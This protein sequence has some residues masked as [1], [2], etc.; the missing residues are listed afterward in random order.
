MEA[1]SQSWQTT[2]PSTRNTLA[3]AVAIGLG[4]PRMRAIRGLLLAAGLFV[5]YVLAARWMFVHW[6][7]WLNLVYPL[8]ALS[9]NYLALTVYYYVSEERQRKQIKETFRQYVSPV[10]V[11]QML[12]DPA[13]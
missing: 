6:R 9:V 4:L 5:L 7:V 12:K 13:A 11:E 8:L 10:V 1:Q 2:G 3:L